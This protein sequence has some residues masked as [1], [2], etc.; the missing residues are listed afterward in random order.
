V[1]F[2]L[3]RENFLKGEGVVRKQKSSP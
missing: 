3:I 1:K 2:F